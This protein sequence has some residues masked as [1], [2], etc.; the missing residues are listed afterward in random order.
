MPLSVP[1]I[2]ALAIYQF[3]HIYNA[4][5]WPLLVT[6]KDVWRTVQVGVSYLV[7]G[8]VEEYGKVIAAAM[9]AMTPAVIA[10]IFGQDYI[11]KGMVS[12]GIKG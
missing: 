5:F 4:Y 12:G 7:T 10:F 11:I 6:N 3:V 2:S 9:V 1:T 8:D